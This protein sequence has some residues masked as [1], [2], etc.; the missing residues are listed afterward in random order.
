MTTTHALRDH[1]NT[2][3]PPVVSAEEWQRARDELLVEEKAHTRAGDALAAKRRRLPMVEVDAGLAVTGPDGAA[4]LLEMFEGRR[5]LI[6]Y[7]HMLKPEDEH[8][9][10]GCSAVTDHVG[11]LAHLNVEDVTFA[12]EAAAPI[13]EFQAYM[14]RMGR[15]DIPIYSSAGSTFRDELNPSPSGPGSFGL[16]V[17]LRDGERV[18]RTYTSYG[19]GVEGVLFIDVT[20]YGPA[21]VVRG[22]APRLA[23][24]SHLLVRQDPRRVH[25]R[26]A[27]RHGCSLD[28]R[29]GG[30]RGVKPPRNGWMRLHA[31]P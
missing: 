9:C 11:H 12:M 16:S 3:V 15:P 25:R 22:L 17:F 10:P 18:Y 13:D 8:P 2:P 7:H 19:R 29:A 28:N 27:R 1:A 31:R 26:G 23:S 24:A 21:G 20:P 4:T 30:R 6:V 5:Q 14:A